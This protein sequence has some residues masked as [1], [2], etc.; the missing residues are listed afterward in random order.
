MSHAA[1]LF[2][3]YFSPYRHTLME[4]VGAELTGLAVA[5]SQT[6]DAEGRRWEVATSSHYRQ[7]Q[8]PSR[9][10]GPFVFFGVPLDLLRG[11]RGRTVVLHDDNPANLSMIAWGVL[12]RL[13]GART[14]LWVEHIPDPAKGRLKGAYQRFCSRLLMAASHKVVAFSALSEAY[15]RS[16]SPKARVARM[17]QTTPSPAHNSLPRHGPIRRFGFIGSA[18]SR[19]NLALLIEAFRSLQGDVELH[20]AGVPVADRGD[21]RIHDWGYVDGDRREEFFA[22]IDMLVLPSVSEPWGLVV[23]EAMQRGALAMVSEA[24]GSSELAA[25]VSPDLVFEPT[26]EGIAAA[27]RRTQSLDADALRAR[28]PEALAPYAE[29]AAAERLTA[30]LRG[31]GGSA[32]KAPEPAAPITRPS[33]AAVLIE[34]NAPP[35]S[36]VT[37]R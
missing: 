36:A 33:S 23:N 3:N 21:A 26:V 22:A 37:I 27:L 4:R 20:I 17:V 29:T 32:E 14:L 11:A 9:K 31:F 19:K 5:Y 34:K 2:Q 13:L 7:Q 10:I 25:A 12:Y 8:L 24:C 16:I 6:P 30:I 35:K 28:L 15:V 18:Q 1:I